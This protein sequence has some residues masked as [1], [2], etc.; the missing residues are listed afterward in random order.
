MDKKHPYSVHKIKYA[1]FIEKYS[2]RKDLFSGETIKWK[3]DDSYFLSDFN[4]RTNLRKYLSLIGKEAGIKYLSEYLNRRK[5][6]KKIEFA[7]SEFEVMSL[8]FPSISYIENYYGEGAFDKICDSA[9]LRPRY[10]YL[11]IPSFTKDISNKNFLCDTREQKMLQLPNIE[12]RKL[13]FGDYGIEGSN[14]F[15]E[16][17]SLNDF[18]GT[19]SAGYE[20]FQKEIELAILNGGYIVVLIEEKYSNLQSFEYMPHIRSKCDWTFISHRF[21]ELVDKYPLAI[22]FLAV[23]GRKEA[24]RVIQQIYKLEVNRLNVDLQFL[25]NKGEL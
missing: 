10:N 5:I 13:D 7:P 9:G 2:P 3:S 14:I 4:T 16:R 1:D 22:Q 8:I 21:R 25:Y 6:I 24:A 23:D 20:R 17:K 11:D 19:M 15:I 12:I 18:L